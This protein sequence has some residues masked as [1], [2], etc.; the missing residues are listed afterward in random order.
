MSVK[1][2]LN[3]T[4]EKH[5]GFNLLMFQKHLKQEQHK[6]AERGPVSQ[7]FIYLLTQ[8][9]KRQVMPSSLLIHIKSIRL[10]VLTKVQLGFCV[11]APAT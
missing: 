9:K 11:E 7:S 10:D 3:Q 4:E 5:L 1:S 6:T 2:H 8:T